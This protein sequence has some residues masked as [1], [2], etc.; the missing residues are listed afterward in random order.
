M[1]TYLLPK[2]LGFLRISIEDIIPITKHELVVVLRLCATSVKQ[3]KRRM[4]PL[5][6]FQSQT[7]ILLPFQLNHGPN[8]N[9]NLSPTRRDF[10]L[11]L[12]T[13]LRLAPSLIVLGVTKVSV[14]N[15]LYNSEMKIHSFHM[16][17]FNCSFYL[18]LGPETITALQL[19][20]QL[21]L[22]TQHGQDK[23]WWISVNWKGKAAWVSSSKD[24]YLRMTLWK[25][26]LGKR[27]CNF[28]ISTS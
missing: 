1:W 25:G 13:N 20:L 12:S 16:H 18:L 19:Q 11:L 2:L 6:P 17:M 28:L 23:Y 4:T 21:Q 7:P 3:I 14:Q 22:Q 9:A 15:S 8:S 5:L 27:I 26:R 24:T 10:K